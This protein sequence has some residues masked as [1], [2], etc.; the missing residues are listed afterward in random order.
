MFWW[1]IIWLIFRKVKIDWA[2][3]FSIVW[4]NSLKFHWNDK[5]N[6]IKHGLCVCVSHTDNRSSLKKMLKKI[7]V[8]LKYFNVCMCCWNTVP[9]SNDQ[10][11][12]RTFLCAI[13][14]SYNEKFDQ[15]AEIR[16]KCRNFETWR[17]FCCLFSSFFLAL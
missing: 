17:A 6:G 3:H 4:E 14:I 2:E 10:I 1:L 9:S 12:K 5:V 8:S 15:N 13:I 11:V 7:N 16:L